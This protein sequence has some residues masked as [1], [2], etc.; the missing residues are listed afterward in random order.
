ML[1]NRETKI[2]LGPAGPNVGQI[3]GKSHPH[4]GAL[5][6]KGWDGGEAAIPE[7]NDLSFASEIIRITV[8][9]RVFALSFLFLRGVGFDIM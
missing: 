3:E 2:N 8:R 9:T 4:P 7:V 5:G 1:K 6:E